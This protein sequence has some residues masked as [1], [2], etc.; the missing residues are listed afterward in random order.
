MKE[1]SRFIRDIHRTKFI[2]VAKEEKKYEVT[3]NRYIKAWEGQVQSA[4]KKAEAKVSKSLDGLTPEDIQAIIEFKVGG[5]AERLASLGTTAA[6]MGA[7]QASVDMAAVATFNIDMTAIAEYYAQHSAHLVDT[8]AGGIQDRLR[9][10]L[11]DAVKDGATIEDAHKRIAEVFDGPVTIKVPEKTNE[12]GE[13]LRRAYQYEMN[14]DSYTT[15]LARS[16]IQRAVNN[17]RIE[18]YIQS[19]I[20]KKVRWVANPGACEYCVPK[21]G[22][23]YNVEDSQDL[24]PLHPNCR[25]T[26]IVSEYKNYEETQAGNDKFANPEDIYADPNGVG[27]ADFFKLNDKEFDQVQKLIGDGKEDEALKILKEKLK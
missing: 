15:M 24:I 1:T 5:A 7:V 25:C 10:I 9:V 17:G 13:T 14:K 19:D 8:L 27:I 12:A 20:A 3:I 23:E 16:E 4:L 11:T 6:K 26:W 22:E 18:G 2:D 21:N